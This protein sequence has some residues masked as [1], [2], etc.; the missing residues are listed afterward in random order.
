[1]RVEAAQEEAARAR[2]QVSESKAAG[3][4]DAAVV[5]AGMELL[6]NAANKSI[7]I[8]AQ[9]AGSQLNTVEVMKTA[10]ELFRPQTDHGTTMLLE[11]LKDQSTKM[12]QMQESNQDSCVR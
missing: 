11:A 4:I 3:T 10:A 9:H 1:M 8:V 7:D 2:E 6:A 12:I 5:N